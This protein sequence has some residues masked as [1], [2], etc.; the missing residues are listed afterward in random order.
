MA[1]ISKVG[2][3]DGQIVYAETVYRIIDALTGVDNRDIYVWGNLNVTGSSEFFGAMKIYGGNVSLTGSLFSTALTNDNSATQL[4]V[5]DATTGQFKYRD[6]STISGS[7][8]SGS[9]TPGGTDQAIQ[10]NSGSTFSGSNSLTYDYTNKVFKVDSVQ[11]RGSGSNVF[12]GTGSG[13]VNIGNSNV[14]LG[15]QSLI[16]N[17]SGSANIGIGALAVS[18]N[19]TG[20]DNIGIGYRSLFN[21]VGNRNVAIGTDALFLQS[22][23]IGSVAIGYNAG[24]YQSGSNKL[25]IAN[26]GSFTLIGGDFGARS[27]YVS[28]TLN[29]S[30]SIIGTS[31]WAV[32]ASWAPSIPA[33]TTGSYT[34]SFI[35]SHSGSFTGSFIGDLV[36]FTSSQWTSSGNNVSRSTGSVNITGS[37][38]VLGN[39]TLSGS[40][41][42]T[43]TAR[44]GT[45]VEVNGALPRINVWQGGIGVGLD[46]YNNNNSYH[47]FNFNS[48]I[49]TSYSNLTV[50]GGGVFEVIDTASSTIGFRM[51]EV[52]NFMYIGSGVGGSGNHIVMSLASNITYLQQYTQVQNGMQILKAPYYSNA[53][54]ALVDGSYPS[55]PFLTWAGDGYFTYSGSIDRYGNILMPSNYISASSFTG[56]LLG[57]ASQATSA[58]YFQPAG[59]NT[60]V[61]FNRSGSFSASAD[62]T[63][64]GTKLMLGVPNTLVSATRLQIRGTTTATGTSLISLWEDAAGNAVLYFYDNG[65]IQINSTTIN[66]YLKFVST[67][68]ITAK[69][70]ALDSGFG[71]S[72]FG[73]ETN[74]PLGVITNNSV[75]SVFDTT[76]ALYIGGNAIPSYKL[77][78]V[79]TKGTVGIANTGL[80]T[81]GDIAFYAASNGTIIGNLYL[82][83]SNISAT[84]AVL[85]N[86]KNLNTSSTANAQQNLQ[87]QGASA[88]DPFTGYS[89]SGIQD[90]TI[91]V[92]NSDSDKFKINSSNGPSNG[93]ERLT[94]TTGGLVGIN[95]P[96][97]TVGLD[98]KGSALISGSLRVISGSIT[99]SLDGTASWALNVSGGGGGG[100]SKWTGSSIISRFGDVGITGSLI[101]GQTLINN[102]TATNANFFGPSAGNNATNANNSNFFGNLAG[103]NASNASNANFFGDG[104]GQ[105]SVDANNSNFFGF[106]A[107]SSSS[108]AVNSNFLGS[109][110][111][112]AASN[113]R[114]SN[115]FGNSAGQSAES[116][117][118]SSFFG[119]D[120]G[121]QAT[122]ASNSNFFGRRAGSNAVSAS[123]SNFFGFDAGSGSTKASNSNLFGQKVG[124]VFSG[125]NILSNNII[126]GT[127]ISL[128]NSASDSLNIGGIIFGTGS[129]STITGNPSITPSNGRIGINVV[130]PNAS[131]HVS[132][133]GIFTGNVSASSFTGSLLGTSSWAVSA[134]W[135]PYGT[136]NAAADNEIPKSDGTNLVGS[137]L[138]CTSAGNLI[139]GRTTDAATAHSIT[140]QGSSASVDI[141]ISPKGN[142][143]FY[144][145]G[146]GS[147]MFN[148]TGATMGFFGTPPVSRA[149]QLTSASTQVT[150]SAPGTPDYNFATVQLAGY[151]FSTQDEG[152]TLLSVI[153]NLQ[154]RVNELETKLQAYG[155]LT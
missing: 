97:P 113:A 110:A 120:A 15:F 130:A 112:F 107:G 67:T 145:T 155:L 24:Y 20:S 125:N 118:H 92:D 129:Y 109:N 58:S 59:S 150:H 134:S 72:T 135:A 137:G 21:G 126:I 11:V 100:G 78:V 13:V 18:A 90:W 38:N 81:D 25:Y 127:N 50:S 19:V 83:D 133:G 23:D 95:N 9:G 10:F 63:W 99:G 2:I 121:F 41:D 32:S 122:S 61:Q 76:G 117:S 1:L 115:F 54:L 144:V 147:T 94:I 98:V 26:T 75:I 96:N 103:A 138:S 79:G 27:V 89:I 33:T 153:A 44:I 111:G 35:G 69:L 39:T 62:F 105:S 45:Y 56:S 48:P 42:T 140:S 40:L 108:L 93:S 139:L 84:N 86:I 77:H 51:Y 55:G 146:N 74:H 22:T 114:D 12:I 65:S 43:G 87:V 148:I 8:G 37:L 66:P 132:G 88:G 131:L 34:G 64:D 7:G 68:G 82:M 102:S 5:I 149:T 4:V 52:N 136:T 106:R 91:G 128:P 60:Q 14:G 49:N 124:S 116:A 141:S 57:T 16:L 36:G 152:N 73:S 47:L 151:G 71:G 29:V 123:N 17:T 143:I 104:A 85:T 28:G 70:Q 101:I 31:S 30:Q 119:A 142:G 80:T 154:T 53:A 46:I 6:V 3:V